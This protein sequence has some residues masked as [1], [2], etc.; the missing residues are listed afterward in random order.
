[1]ARGLVFMLIHS[2]CIPGRLLLKFAQYVLA[3]CLVL[4]P[5]L[6]RAA[7]VDLETDLQRGLNK[8][9]AIVESIIAKM[10]QGA[11]VTSEISRLKIIAEDVRISNLLL[12]E[13]FILREEKVKSLGA[14]AVERH[15]NMAGGYRKALMEYLGLIDGL[16]SG[17]QEASSVKLQ[18]QSDEL[19]SLLDKLLPKKKR[20]IIGSLPYKH[21]NYPAQEPSS[22]PSIAPAYKGG[23]KTVSA[24][25][26]KST[27]EAPISKE[28]AALAQ[29]LNWQPVAI[30][31]Y[32]KNTID[33]E[34][35]WGCMKGAEETLRQ[36]SG[37]DCDQA[38]L[39]AALLRASG[40]PTRYVRG[41]VEILPD[42]EKVKNLIGIDDPARTAE[43]FQKAG[44]P[45]KPIIAGGKIANIQIEHIWIESQIPYANYR[46][47]IIDEHGKTWLGLDTSIKVKNYVVNDPKDIFEVSA[48]SDQLSAVRDEYLIA[49]R[50]QTPLEYLKQK[51]SAMSYELTDYVRTRTLPEEH[52]KIL[53]AGMQFVEKTI[54]GEFAAIPEELLH[55][56]RFAASRQ[57][58][59]GSTQGETL[60]D[61]TLPLYKLS[62]QQL[63][64]TY[65]PE[66][67]EDQEIIA[68]YGG[69]DNAPAYLIRL[70]PVLKINGERI[71][72]ATD[73]LPMG[74]DFNLTIELHSPS[75]NGGAAPVETITNKLIAGNL[76]VIG[77]TSQKAIITPSPLAGEGGGE[78]AKDA[79]RLLYEE[80]NHY[81]DRWNQAEDELASLL[82]LTISRPL[83]AVVTVGG[84]IDVTY[85][86]DIPHGFTWKGVYV[87]A[88]HRIIETVQSS[89]FGVQSDRQRLFMKLS[90][91]QGSILENRI[92][93][94]DFKVE[95]ISTAK[96]FQLATGNPPSA[97]SIITIDKSNI[98]AILPTLPFNDNI[99][100]D[101]VNAVNQG[102]ELRTPNVELVYK[103]WSGVGW[104]KE[105]IA[106]GEAGWMLSGSIAGGMTAWGLDKW[107]AYY[108]DLLSHPYTEPAN[109]D[110]A[111]ARNIQKLASTDMQQGVVG[112]VL[113]KFLTVK[114][115]DQKGLAV[116]NVE[117]T[118]TVKA[119]GGKLLAFD[120]ATATKPEKDTVVVKTSVIGMAEVEFLLGKE[121]KSNTTFWW[122]AGNTYAQQVGE[123]LVDAALTSGAGLT[124]PFTAYGFPK[125]AHHITPLHGD[126]TWGAALSFA[127]F[128][129]VAVEDEYNNPVSN[130]PVTF[131]AAEP[132]QNPDEPN[133]PITAPVTKKAYLLE[134]ST[135]CISNAPTWGTCGDTLKSSLTL[136]T[137][138]TGAAAQVILGGMED[139]IYVIS[140]SAPNKPA[141]NLK[142][143]TYD[144]YAL[145]NRK[146]D[147]TED[148]LR[149]MFVTY[150]YEADQY[151]NSINAGKTGSTISVKA[152]L[153][154]LVEEETTKDV[155]ISCASG[156]LTCNKIVGTRQYSTTT[157][158]FGPSVT[159]DGISGL[160]QGDGN[161][162]SNYTLKPGVNTLAINGTGGLSVISTNMACPSTCK[163]AYLMLTQTDFTT[164]RV[165]GVEV[166]TQPLPIMFI[167]EKGYL[168]REQ[169][170]TYTIEP[171]ASDYKAMNAYVMIYKDG[172]VIASIPSETKGQGTVTLSRGFQ[173]DA[174]SAYKA[175]VI[176]NYGTGVEIKGNR[177][178]IPVA[179]LRVLS[180]EYPEKSA[181]EIKFGTGA[182]QY[183]WQKKKIYQINMQSAAFINNCASLTGKISVVNQSGQLATLPSADGQAYAA[184]YQLKSDS[185]FNGCGL[186]IIDTLANKTLSYFIVSNRSRA[187]LNEGWFNYNV[188]DKAVLYGGIGNK[189]K[190]EVSQSQKYIPIEPVGV[191]VLGIDG[192]RQDVL[193]PVEE[194]HVNEPHVDYYVRSSELKGLCDVLGGK[195]DGMISTHCD[196]TGWENKHIKLKDVTA[197]FPSITLASWASIFTGKMPNETGITGNEFFARDLNNSQGVPSRRDGTLT[198]ILNPP[199]IVSFDSGAF[200]GYDI[201][202]PSSNDFFIPRQFFW[203]P[204]V[205]PGLTPQNDTRVLTAEKTLFESISEM[206]GV[207]KYLNGKDA[208]AVTVAY[209]HYSRGAS[210]W[211]TFNLLDPTS[212]SW[213]VASMMDKA[214]WNRFEEYLKGKFLTNNVRNTVPFSPLTVWYLPGLDHNAH[215]AGMDTYKSYFIDKTDDYI[216]N[217]TKWLKSND[218]FDNKI[219]VIVADHGHTAMPT[220]LKYKDTNWLGQQVDRYAEMSCA[221]K[222][223]FVDPQ[224]SDHIT[225][226]QK[227]EKANNNL[228]IWEL[229]E[230]FSAI[231]GIEGAAVGT[232]YKI[233][234]PKEIEDAFVNSG[235]PDEFSP[236][237]DIDKADIVAAL[238]GPMAH[239]YSMIGTDNKTLGEIA[240][241]F[242][243]MFSGPYSNEAAKWY[244]F[245]DQYSYIKFRVKY[246]GRLR[247]SLDKILIRLEDG[248]YY[249]FGGLDDNGDPI[250]YNLSSS[251]SGIDYVDGENR[252]NGL[253]NKNRSGDIVL[254]MKDDVYYPDNESIADHRFTS[255]VACKSWHGSL[256][257]SD[258]YVPFIFAYPGGNSSELEQI[259]RKDALCKSNYSECKANWKLPDIVKEIIS[260]QYK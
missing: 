65:E 111:S 15:R 216:W 74:A 190:I 177:V 100:E 25:D 179:Q 211:L 9:Q 143:Y 169:T 85:L 115:T 53:P 206:E 152:K 4:A 125:A 35:Y 144:L 199:G 117:V 149:Q 134:T 187:A 8:S 37:N 256:N 99:K 157:D 222:T 2:T 24:E 183:E 45:F 141:V 227:A 197:I 148:P 178:T 174:N 104:I 40:F 128:V 75:V 153:Y 142:L 162:M 221:L 19:K 168:E 56:V 80:A 151:G 123:N 207:Q 62:N 214:S 44:I 209:S 109:N 132:V 210:N 245:G 249:V 189:V 76:S 188:S 84:V 3:L 240:E 239:L 220:D 255:G 201:V 102:F 78:G 64:I 259:L 59:V 136:T 48:V 250:T 145:Y 163:P 231:G 213:P 130:V 108:A 258:S 147:N 52:M 133:C 58:T 218:E 97:T 98:D 200:K 34:W 11:S 112:S 36:K 219:F 23:N 60:F 14:K 138:H 77:I 93:E 1:M 182:D 175:Q 242:R 185:M 57:H 215:E 92:F 208:D 73:G 186:Q 233:L 113:S 180:D 252:V 160:D 43:F 91:L 27:V 167:N 248:K 46:G 72:V 107:P 54:T 202:G 83:P 170:I 192:L 251:L 230:V 127:G 150:T 16:P 137:D 39:L 235:V 67:V 63:V 243:V 124:K 223:D 193:Y 228:H 88:D 172:D 6:G 38:T 159:F 165:Y 236:T 247:N 90:S 122:N 176:L 217:L 95:S 241:V 203:K 114:V 81:I 139:A 126:G 87:D 31:E 82:H 118:F 229:G 116:K 13:R 20:P 234:V 61:I 30:Y 96:L 66:T 184:E 94:D 26:T 22:A 226:A 155:S 237:S 21:L 32:V 47:A 120:P 164:V 50:T 55:K 205:N 212:L 161:Y 257:R 101:M 121:T 196:A 89:V 29:S 12:E 42:I 79:E 28:L 158:Y 110:P 49:I 146:C 41:T 238:N 129:S 71:V 224:N 105:N 33:T 173:F 5:L 154:S 191:I 135:A 10:T 171:L 68:S 18:A 7:E 194:Q 156:T 198:P 195:F 181:D 70:R 119:G 140:A 246:A 106:T 17:S 225:G 69:L 131:T 51:L 244:G 260:T 204:T 86:L 103:D 232:Q 254:I 253:N 166:K